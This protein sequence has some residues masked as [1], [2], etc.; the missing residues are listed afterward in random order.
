MKFRKLDTK[1]IMNLELI[2]VLGSLQLKSHHQ[3]KVIMSQALWE[4]GWF[5]E[6]N[7]YSY[8]NRSN[9][10]NWFG[11]G[12]NKRGYA[13]SS[14]SGAS[15]TKAEKWAVYPS[16]IYGIL[17]R[18]AWDKKAFFSPD[19]STSSDDYI[20]RCEKWRYW[21]ENG[22]DMG[23]SSIMKAMVKHY[24]TQFNLI[25][26]VPPLALLSTLLYFK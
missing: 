23:Y 10:T 13:I 7:K 18:F 2:A 5:N 9:D 6:T 4:T 21:V 24:D 15:S 3:L 22:R 12:Y 25:L 1:A 8:Y 17:D 11:M 14:F 16:S 26:A 20:Y 19:D